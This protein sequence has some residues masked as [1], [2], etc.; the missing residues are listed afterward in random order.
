MDMGNSVVIAGSGREGGSRKE[1]NG[2][3]KNTIKMKKYKYNF[4]NKL[5]LRGKTRDMFD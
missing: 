3:G 2:N 4:T 1:T 5:G